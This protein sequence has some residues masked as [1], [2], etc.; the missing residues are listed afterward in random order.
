[1]SAE[2]RARSGGGGSFADMEVEVGGFDF[3]D[4]VVGGDDPAPAPEVANAPAKAK[5]PR[6][7]RAVR[8]MS[9]QG[10]ALY[11]LFIVVVT[12]FGFAALVTWVFLQTGLIAFA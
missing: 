8:R 6:V 9:P 7:G 10:L 5:V 1:M 2:D 3:S 11:K 12:S 4:M